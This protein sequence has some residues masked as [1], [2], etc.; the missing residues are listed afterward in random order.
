MKLDTYIYREGEGHDHMHPLILPAMERAIERDFD[1]GQPRTLCDLGCGYGKMA[2]YFR[3]RGWDVLGVDP[4]SSG[5]ERGGATYP[6]PVSY[7]HLTLPT[8]PYV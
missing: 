1:P 6:E 2:N 4:S 8:T 7:T 3:L 5:I